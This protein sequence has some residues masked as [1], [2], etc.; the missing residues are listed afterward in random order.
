MDD[1]KNGASFW[2]RL[3]CSPYV[4]THMYSAILIWFLASVT[5]FQK[6][7]PPKPGE[8]TRSDIQNKNCGVLRTSK[9]KKR[10]RADL[11]LA[12]ATRFVMV[13]ITTCTRSPLCKTGTHSSSNIFFLLVRMSMAACHWLSHDLLGPIASEC[14][15]LSGL[16]SER[17]KGR[18]DFS[19][20]FG[21]GCGPRT[22]RRYSRERR[23]QERDE[24]V[25]SLSYTPGFSVRVRRFRAAPNFQTAKGKKGYH[26]TW[27]LASSKT[28]W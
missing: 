24:K 14:S 11:P 15:R 6:K 9:T 5:L 26:Q 8:R 13:H 18:G 4:P 1:H 16:N 28:V 19:L 23:K 17:K 21:R 22:R 20:H 2:R 25:W 27:K 12:R 7:S 10:S 3:F